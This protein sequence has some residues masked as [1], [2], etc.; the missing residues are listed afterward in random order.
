MMSKVILGKTGIV[1][2]KNGFGALPVQRVSE[3]EAG[4]LLKK[5][6]DNGI[7]F[8][9]TARAYSDSEKKIGLYLADVRPH[10]TITTKT[11]AKRADDFWRDLHTSLAT[12][13]TD[14]IDVYQL[15]NPSFCPKPGDEPGLYDAML[16]AKRQGK[17]RFIGITNH[18]IFVAE[19]AVQ[20]GLYDTL[21]FPFSYLSTERETALARLCKENNVGFIA[22]KALCGGLITNSAAAYAYLNQPGFDNVLPIWGIQRDTELDEFI[23]YRHNPPALTDELLQVIEKDTSELAGNFCRGCGYCMPTCPAN[24]QINN[25]AR[26][27]QLIR[28]SPSAQWLTPEFQRVMHTIENCTECGICRTKCPYGIDT[29]TLLKENLEDYNTILSGKT[30]I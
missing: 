5:A 1:S 3:K 11:M 22:M 25:C 13:K 15:H 4:V 9:D 26:M 10:I 27:I 24:I 18:S 28:R 17:I 21:Q 7:T 20:S 19:E 8:F 23:G 12:L 30:V 29:P 16:E 2:D 6:Y 14:Y